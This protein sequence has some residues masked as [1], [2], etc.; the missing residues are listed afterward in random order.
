MKRTRRFRVALVAVAVAFAVCAAAFGEVLPG[1]AYAAQSS[2]ISTAA[3]LNIALENAG[4]KKSGVKMLELEKEDG[5]R[6]D[7]EFV[8]KSSKAKYEYSI[9]AAN[10]KI[11]EKTIEYKYKTSKSTK[12]IGKK[13]ARKIAAKA[14]GKSYNVVKTGTCTFEKSKKLRKYEVKFRSGSYKYECEILA[15]NGKIIEYEYEYIGH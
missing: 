3:A 9:S 6:I 15:H 5:N 10:G 12:K 4:V 11:L 8:K 7:V 13:K 2:K 14:S 1:K